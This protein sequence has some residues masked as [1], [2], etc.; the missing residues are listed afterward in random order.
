MIAGIIPASS[1]IFPVLTSIRE[2]GITPPR[3]TLISRKPTGSLGLVK[4][5][6][7][8]KSFGVVILFKSTFGR[9]FDN[10]FL[11]WFINN[12]RNQGDGC[13]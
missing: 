12:L 1:K 3:Y 11:R 4:D 13:T 2:S 6:R 5:D 8:L 10:R 7:E 9:G